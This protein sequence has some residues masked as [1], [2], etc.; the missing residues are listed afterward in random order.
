MNADY[1][2]KIGVVRYEN[3]SHHDFYDSC[4]DLF[5]D[6]CD[7]HLRF[8]LRPPGH[9][10]DTI[11]G[12]CPQELLTGGVGGDDITFGSTV[13]RLSNPLSVSGEGTWL[14]SFYNNNEDAVCCLVVVTL[15][16]M[17]LAPLQGN[18]YYNVQGSFQLLVEVYDDDVITADDFVDVIFAAPYNLSVGDSITR[19]Y[20]GRR[21]RITFTFQVRCAMNYYGGSCSTFCLEADDDV[22]G[23]YTC[24]P[25]SGEK[26]C[27]PGYRNSA[28]YNC[29]TGIYTQPTRGCSAC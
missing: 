27:R 7:T 14:V 11:G 26:D 3:P 25:L 22:N 23:H 17:H 9:S 28:T 24:N 18:L 4:C 19:S 20:A 15:L 13:G 5:C 12:Y 10:T 16:L 29:N 1:E 8:C 2:L 6:S 21:V